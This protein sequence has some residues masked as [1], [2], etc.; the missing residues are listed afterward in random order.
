MQTT[1]TVHPVVIKGTNFI[2]AS[3]GDHVQDFGAAYRRG[4]S[5]GYDLESGIDPLPD[6]G[7]RL[8][9]TVLIQDLG[10]NAIRACN[11]FRAT[12]RSTCRP[13]V[14][15]VSHLDAFPVTISIPKFLSGERVRNGR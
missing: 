10:N 2:D 11:V 13:T 8:R 7:E 3:S 9:D 1:T 14:L 4:D 5:S 6:G 12:H 15:S